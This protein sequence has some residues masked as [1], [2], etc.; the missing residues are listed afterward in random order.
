MVG[1]PELLVSRVHRQALSAPSSPPGS[2][3]PTQKPG[4][5]PGW[6]PGS[7]LSSPGLQITGRVEIRG[8]TRLGAGPP[9][10]DPLLTNTSV[11][12]INSMTHLPQGSSPDNLPCRPSLCPGVPAARRH[13]HLLFWTAPPSPALTWVLSVLHPLSLFPSQPRSSG[14]VSPGPK[15]CLSQAFPTA[16]PPAQLHPPSDLRTPQKCRPVH[17]RLLLKHLLWI[18][19]SS[20]IKY[21]SHRLRVP[22]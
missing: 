14:S 8:S 17:I 5:F 1:V 4:P 18:P 9:A 15:L 21:K 3:H 22:P 12:S 11:E 20:S 6:L 7:C 19:L 10:P 2:L 13:Q 16:A